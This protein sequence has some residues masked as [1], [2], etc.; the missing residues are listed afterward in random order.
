MGLAEQERKRDEKIDGVV[1][2]MSPAP[3]YKHGIINGN[4]YR[5]IGNGLRNSLCLVFMEN[6]DY[7]YHAE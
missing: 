1:Y 3:G 4:I 2:D 6:L 7:K 5:I